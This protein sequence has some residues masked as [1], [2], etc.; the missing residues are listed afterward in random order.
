MAE[1]VKP[2]GID[3]GCR[4]RLRNGALL[5]TVMAREWA[6]ERGVSVGRCASEANSRE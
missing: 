4:P 3:G 5:D 6:V 1:R 2:R